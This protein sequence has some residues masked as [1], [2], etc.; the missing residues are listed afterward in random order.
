MN[1]RSYRRFIIISAAILAFTGCSSKKDSGEDAV[2]AVMSELE[3]TESSAEICSSYKVADKK[4]SILVLYGIT[5]LVWGRVPGK[6]SG[7]LSQD[8][9][10]PERFRCVTL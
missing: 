10:C 3:T 4:I 9:G 1:I 2:A 7:A 6:G 8:R 5:G